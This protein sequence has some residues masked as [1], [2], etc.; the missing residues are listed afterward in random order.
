ML[1]YLTVRALPR[2]AASD[3]AVSLDRTCIATP[4]QLNA[5]NPRMY[6]SMK[7][8]GLRYVVHVTWGV[9]R[10]CLSNHGNITLERNP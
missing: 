5:L 2:H 8:F 9:H 4:I 3:H 7:A 1:F 10:A 6:A